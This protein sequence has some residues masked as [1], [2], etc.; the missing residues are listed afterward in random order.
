MVV[1]SLLCFVSEREKHTLDTNQY[2]RVTRER[3]S[4]A[5][6]T[7]CGILPTGMLIR[8]RTNQGFVIVAATAALIFFG[9]GEK[10]ADSKRIIGQQKSLPLL[11]VWCV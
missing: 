1:G 4:S 10:Q 2:Y 11:T 3:Q 9:N 7:T 5:D 8:S 6:N